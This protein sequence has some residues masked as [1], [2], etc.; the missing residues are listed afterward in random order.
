M[1]FRREVSLAKWNHLTSEVDRADTTS[2]GTF[3]HEFDAMSGASA[4]QNTSASAGPSLIR[5]GPPIVTYVVIGLCLLVYLWSSLDPRSA[6]SGLVRPIYNLPSGWWALFSTAL[7]HQGIAHILFD[8][9]AFLALGR[10]VE[11]TAG[12]VRFII[13]LLLVAWMASFSQLYF[14]RAVGVGL[15][16][17]VYGVFGFM[18]GAAPVNRL[19]LW[20]VQKNAAMLIGWAV[21]CIVFTQLKVM[22]IANA[23]H[24]GGLIFGALCGL[25]YGL[26]RFRWGV[27]T[28]IL[29]LLLW[30]GAV[31]FG[32]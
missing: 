5:P 2:H 21:L 15:S 30:S 14:Q 17:V 1:F 22:N 11:L 12:K 19:F 10:I 8:L 6:Y 26:P 29:A 13:L 28:V 25:Y 3:Y 32:P 24:F 16:G 4:D 18:L 9:A 23:A 31:I 7:V 20:F 27:A